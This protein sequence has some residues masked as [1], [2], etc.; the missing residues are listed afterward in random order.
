MAS[1]LPEVLLAPKGAEPSN[2][3]YTPDLGRLIADLSS[4]GMSLHKISQISGMPS[5][6]TLQRWV[7]SHPDFAPLMRSM[8]AIRALHY[9][10]AAIVAAEEAKGKDAD[11][12]KFEAYKWAAE[13]N[14]PEVYGKKVTHAGDAKNPVVLQVVTGFGPPN[15]WQTPPTLAADGTI[16]KEG[17][18]SGE[19]T[20]HREN[21]AGTEEG[22]KGAGEGS[23]RPLDAHPSS[24]GDAD[25]RCGV[26]TLQAE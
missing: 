10:E 24:S 7:D 8:R 3:Q 15:K 17:D 2:I 6:T 4:Q 13:V 21:G 11:R 9:E 26:K 20:A 1:D 14:N 12:L 23:H 16:L 22:C 25:R 18:L 19:R 5:Y